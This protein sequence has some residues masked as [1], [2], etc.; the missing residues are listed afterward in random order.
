MSDWEKNLVDHIVESL[1]IHPYWN[2]RLAGWNAGR[3][4]GFSWHLA[5]F[6][7][8]FLS[9]VLDGSKT[10][11]SRFSVN[12]TEPYRRVAVGDAVLIKSSG[13]PIVAV[14]E[15]R[16]A[17]FYQLDREQLDLI[18]ERFG[19]ELRVEGEAFW[20]DRKEC[21]FATIVGLGNVHRIEPVECD[22]RDK[23]GWVRLRYQP[24]LSF[25]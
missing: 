9:Y 18:R 24:S 25:E 14:A 7:E 17:A 22:K 8:P 5:V 21:C 1:T 10:V 13:G 15:V 3:S 11:E 6:V 16:Q 19:P 2:R 12:R 23:R 4:L 20:E